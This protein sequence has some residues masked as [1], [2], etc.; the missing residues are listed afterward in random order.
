MP[1]I[2]V[3]VIGLTPRSPLIS[4]VGTLVIPLLPSSTKLPDSPRF[5]GTP[6]IVVLVPVRNVHVCGAA[7]AMCDALLTPVVIV[8]TYDVLAVSC[9][10]GVN[11]MVVLVATTL[12]WTA[13]APTSVLSVKLAP[14]SVL[15][16]IGSLKVA[17]TIGSS[18]IAVALLAGK[19]EMTVGATAV[20]PSLVA[21]SLV[22][23]S[24]LAPSVAVVESPP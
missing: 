22:V 18:G 9:N 24:V 7:I 16:S 13:I 11:A 2:A 19:L 17:L 20:I 14:V 12:P 6:T 21:P 15:T 8:A 5:T 3:E 23:P 10:A 1:V 4:D